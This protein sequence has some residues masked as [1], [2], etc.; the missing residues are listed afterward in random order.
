MKK[1]LAS[2]VTYNR[3]ELLKES[4]EHLLAQTYESMDIL[5][6]DNFSN[7]GT[8]EYI[9][10]LIDD[11][12][13]FYV[14]TGANLG[15]A[16]GFNWGIKEGVQRG[17]EFQWIMDDDTMPEPGAL[18]AF[19]KADE[20]IKDY[21]FLCSR[22][23]WTDGTACN[24]NIPGQSPYWHENMDKITL[25]YMPV[26]ST[27]F[28]SCFIPSKIVMEVGLP[29]KEFFIWGDDAEYTRR[30]SMKHPCYFVS[31]SVVIHKMK[32]NRG[33]DIAD[34][35]PDRLFRYTYSYR[36]LYYVAKMEPNRLPKYLYYYRVLL[37]VKSIMKKGVEGKRKK[38]KVIRQ[39]LRKRKKFKP[40]VEFPQV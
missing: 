38:L 27:S 17:Y 26:K 30:I 7:D 19:M 36:N 25:G 3:K 4:I 32:S 20:L 12:K 15:G 5:I 16:G 35:H 8:Y 13:V 23:L 6:V 31:D 21:G 28:V 2:I 37:D 33:T 24:M 10:D 11:T 18:D 9:K 14:N 40:V 34:E 39:G 1:V 29:F 22:V